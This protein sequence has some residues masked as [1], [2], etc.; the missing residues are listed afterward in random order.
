MKRCATSFVLLVDI[1]A[2]RFEIVKTSCLV[3]LCCHVD[4]VE[5]EVV[6]GVLVCSV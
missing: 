5:P 3:A 2:M 1:Y 6:Y 4:H